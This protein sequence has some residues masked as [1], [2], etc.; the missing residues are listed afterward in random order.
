MS[1]N[2]LNTPFSSCLLGA[3]KPRV[4]KSNCYE[5]Q[6]RTNRVNRGPHYDADAKKQLLHVVSCERYHIIS[7][8]QAISSL[9][10][11]ELFH[12]LAENF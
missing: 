7:Y 3:F 11:K 10:S 1:L 4:S 5:S 6:R 8:R 12:F 2:T 9:L